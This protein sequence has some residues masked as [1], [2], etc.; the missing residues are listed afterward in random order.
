MSFWTNIGKVFKVATNVAGGAVSV[1]NPALG[2]TIGA[3]STAIAA[4]VSQI[5]TDRAAEPGLSKKQFLMQEAESSLPFMVPMIESMAGHKIQNPA[6]FEKFVSLSTDAAKAFHNAFL[7][8][9]PAPDP[10]KAPAA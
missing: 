4:R 10:A 5:E 7:V 8:P 2:A 6:E 1:W 3:I 9:A